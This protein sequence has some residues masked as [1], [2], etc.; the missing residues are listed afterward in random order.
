MTKSINTE[1]Q[2]IPS[3]AELLYVHQDVAHSIRKISEYLIKR[4]AS[5]IDYDEKF[6]ELIPKFDRASLTLQRLSS[7]ICH[8]IPMEQKILGQRIE[9]LP[10]S[11]PTKNL[12]ST[13][14][15][16]VMVVA[17]QFGLLKEDAD[18]KIEELIAEFSKRE[19]LDR[20]VATD[21]NQ[22]GG[23]HE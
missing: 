4:F 22:T 6:L 13:D 12:S 21:E 20:E 16:M 8:I 15:E 14:L 3:Q 19:E 2:K 17:K 7:I 5:N 10:S 9:L 1:T 11:T 18:E 23:I